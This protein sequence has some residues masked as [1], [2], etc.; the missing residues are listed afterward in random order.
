MDL[1]QSLRSLAATPWLSLAVELSLALGIGANT[2]VFSVV[3]A[4]LL[5]PLPVAE[6]DRLLA[7]Y[8]VDQTGAAGPISSSLPL[9]RANFEDLRR[10]SRSFERLAGWLTLPVALGI[11]DGEAVQVPAQAVTADYFLA[12]GTEAAAGRLFRPE[13]VTDDGRAPAV[14][15]SHDTWQRRFGGDAGVVGGTV[16][17]NGSPYEIVGVAAEGFAGTS[18]LFSPEIWLPLS[19]HG[20]LLTG[21]AREFFATRRGLVLETAGLLAPG[22]GREQAAAEVSAIAARL[23]EL[24]PVENRDRGA[25]VVPL[26]EAAVPPELRTLFAAAGGLLLAVSLLV[27]AIAC[28]NVANLLLAR[29]GARER[30]TALRL[31]LGAGRGRLARALLVDGAVLAL[32]GGVAGLVVA[33]LGAEALWRL[34]PPMLGR[35]PADPGTGGAV[36]AFA[37]VLAAGCALL[38]ALAPLRQA[39]STDL[40][41]LLK[42]RAAA[43]R[44][45]R[46][47]LGS[48]LV[49][50]QVAF[51]LV[52]LVGSGLFLASLAELRDADP[53]F[54]VERL[55]AVSVN[56]ALAGYAPERIGPLYEEVRSEIE[57]LPG[58]AAAAFGAHLPLSGPPPVMRSVFRQGRDVPGESGGTLVAA[59]VVGEGYFETLGV[60]L[61][62]GRPFT[63]A[64]REGAPFVAVVN[65]ALAERLWPEGAVG[66]RFTLGGDERVR[67]VV[68][69]S[70]TSRY[71]SLGEEPM[72]V[73]YLPLAQQGGDSARLFVR[74]DGPPGPL[75]PDLRRR[76]GEL[77]PGVPIGDAATL[78]EVLASS[79]WA[80]RLAAGLLGGF[81]LLALALSALGIYGLMSYRV[82]RRRR[83]IGIR[84]ALGAERREVLG[85]VVR[86]GMLLVAVGTVAGLAAGGLLARAARGLLYGIGAFDPAAFLGAAA[87]LALVALVANLVPARRATRVDPVV[88]LRAE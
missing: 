47:G 22:V 79:L 52:A 13:E 67:E 9:S 7:V 64:D 8:T 81:A 49:V 12:L 55:A 42:E 23:A 28:A 26:A 70:E 48:L 35:S 20:Q 73:L 71:G 63:S 21:P 4:V 34:R 11:E 39:L 15:L 46:G 66:R 84:L 57:S 30:E 85:L 68:G 27:L 88:V 38:F 41:T 24:H 72:P 31:A 60:P 56:P 51:C 65:R 62:A 6:P 16:R 19:M 14:V 3:R 77:A 54:D 1:R 18:R 50:G 53:G 59:D 69:V 44:R 37:L 58:V 32:A 29:A 10:E 17:V 25:A 40:S 36:V 82:E 33:H 76:L 43:G 74:G 83:E 86:R 80:P 61:V 45:R 5:A 78:D 2:A 87:V 75:L